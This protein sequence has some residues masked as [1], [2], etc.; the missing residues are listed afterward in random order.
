MLESRR[1]LRILRRQGRCRRFRPSPERLSDRCLLSAISLTSATQANDQ[2]VEVDYQV[3]VSNLNSL[4]ID[5]YRSAFAQLGVGDQVEIGM[6]TLSGSELT[7]GVHDDVSL[8]L[9]DRSPGVDA[10]A[11]DPAHPFVIA[12]ATGPDGITSSASYQTI[13]VGLVTHGF[14]PTDTAPAW[15]YQIAASLKG[16]GYNDAIA[17]DWAKASHTLEAGEAVRSG[18]KA[19]DTIEKYIE[20]KHG[21]GQP[22]VPAGD[23]VDL[24]LIGHSRGSVVITQAMK[25]LQDNLAK[26]PQAKGG[27][28][29]LTYLDPHPSHGTNV[30]PFSATSRS[31]L[32]AA[33]A[34][35]RIYKDPYPLIVPTHVALAQIDYE[36][37]PVSM[38]VSTTEEG[39]VN[40]W[41]ITY[42]TGIHAAR[43]GTTQFETL[44]LTAPGMTHSSVYEWYQANVVP[45]LGSANPF[46]TGP[47]DAP[48]E[49]NGE[50]LTAT[51]GS[52]LFDRFAYFYDDNPDATSDD[53]T[54]TI[55]WGDG[56]ATTTGSVAGTPDL[57]YFV[58]ATHIYASSGTYQDSVTIR[59]TVGSVATLTGTVVV[60]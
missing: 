57:G 30:A 11:I 18:I 8:A 5:V 9:G 29:E 47:I 32:D 40:P 54:A 14:N 60:S 53:Y 21:Q 41:G 26:I 37:T 4:T 48:I 16:L 19:A 3:N 34:L 20:G 46:V 13:T 10:L 36:N 50:S 33:N 39:Q 56:T 24:Q 7:P 17:F 25:T 12:A 28:W 59:H 2:T 1:G 35:Q 43:G 27:F 52:P 58:L 44:N 55:D 6:V 31:L 23:V 42:P 45:T 38:I 22:N 15:I 49:G 51:A